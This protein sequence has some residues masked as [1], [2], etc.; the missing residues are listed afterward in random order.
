VFDRRR[1]PKQAAA[2]ARAKNHSEKRHVGTC[3]SPAF[4]LER[5]ALAFKVHSSQINIVNHTTAII[6]N[7]VF[8]IGLVVTCSLG[9]S[10]IHRVILEEHIRIVNIID[11]EMINERNARQVP[12]PNTTDESATD[13]RHKA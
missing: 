12:F 9:R 10:R 3:S 8:Y 5:S 2:A 13:K 7:A 11:V 1:L 6:D 4:W